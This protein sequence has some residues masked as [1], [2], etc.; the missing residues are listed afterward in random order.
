MQKDVIN[1]QIVRLCHNVYVKKKTT[2]TKKNNVTVQ[3]SLAFVR[4]VTDYVI[5]Y[6]IFFS[7]VMNTLFFQ[8]DN[9][10]DNSQFPENTDSQFSRPW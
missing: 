3:M 8:F 1:V 2:T 5:L 9:G 6:L 10:K 7:L 4:V